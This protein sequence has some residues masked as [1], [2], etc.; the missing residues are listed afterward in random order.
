[1]SSENR[2]ICFANAVLP[3]K[4]MLNPADISLVIPA[5]LLC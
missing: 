5:I 2:V 3:G 4:M 1:M